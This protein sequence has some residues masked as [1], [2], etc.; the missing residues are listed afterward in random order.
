MKRFLQYEDDSPQCIGRVDLHEGRYRS[1]ATGRRRTVRRSGGIPLR[2][3]G[4]NKSDANQRWV[5]G[6]PNS[7]KRAESVRGGWLVVFQG[8][9]DVL[10]QVQGLALFQNRSQRSRLILPAIKALATCPSTP[11]V[12]PRAGNSLNKN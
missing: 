2:L 10:E 12:T 6:S 7:P 1:D 11:G 4:A 8:E 3:E 9:V 5:L